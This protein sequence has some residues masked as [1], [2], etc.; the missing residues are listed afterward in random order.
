M[1][2]KRIR[3][4]LIL[5]ENEIQL[6]NCVTSGVTVEIYIE[7]ESDYIG[8][9]LSYSD[10]IVEVKSGKYFRESC[11]IWTDGNYLKRKTIL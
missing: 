3:K 5:I 7:K 6:I 8:E 4:R 9:I 1:K 2:N 10:N 11:E